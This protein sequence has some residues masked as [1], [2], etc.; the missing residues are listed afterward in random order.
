MV[1]LERLDHQLD[2]ALELRVPAGGVVLW[3]KQDFFI[4]VG[5][6]IFHR[7]SDVFEPKGELRLSGDAAIDQRLVYVYADNATPG[8]HADDGTEAQQLEPV[9]EYVAV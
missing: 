8:P 1:L 9:S 7:P 2:G 6:A 5:A 3:V 4:R